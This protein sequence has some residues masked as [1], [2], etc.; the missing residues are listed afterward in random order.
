MARIWKA[1]ARRNALSQMISLRRFE[2]ATSYSDV[3]AG[4]YNVKHVTVSI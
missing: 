1:R 4:K 3:L 2:V